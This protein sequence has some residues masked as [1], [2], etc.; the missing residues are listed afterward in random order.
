[1]VSTEYNKEILRMR[2][3]ETLLSVIRKRGERGLPLESVY[4]L[5]Y[6][7]VLFL[8]AYGCIYPNQGTTTKGVTA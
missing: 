6:N 2:I 4:R 5:L 8:R 7:R 3:A 1:M